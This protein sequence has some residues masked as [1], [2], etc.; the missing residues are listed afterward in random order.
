M[1]ILGARPGIAA[2]IATGL[3]AIPTSREEDKKSERPLYQWGAAIP[4]TVIR[5]APALLARRFQD[6]PS[7]LLSPKQ[8][9]LDRTSHVV[10][11]EMAKPA[12]LL[13]LASASYFIKSAPMMI[14]IERLAQTTA[15]VYLNNP[16]AKIGAGLALTTLAC[17]TE[18]GHFPNQFIAYDMGSDMQPD[19]GTL[20]LDSDGDGVPVGLDCDDQNPNKFPLIADLGLRNELQRSVS[21]Q[22]KENAEICP[23]I[24]SG[25]SLE[26]PH[27][28][29]NIEVKGEG[30]VLDGNV[31]GTSVYDQAIRIL[32][33]EGVRVSGFKIQ[34]Y[35]EPASGA[36][37]IRVLDSKDVSLINLQITATSGFYPIRLERSNSTLIDGVSTFTRSDRGIYAEACNYTVIRNTELAA[38]LPRDYPSTGY[39]LLHFIGGIGN[40]VH[41]SRLMQGEGF[42]LFVSGNSDFTANG[43][44]INGNKMSGILLFNVRASIFN[45]NLVNSNGGYGLFPQG[46]TAENQ[47]VGNNFT[48]NVL[49]PYGSREG[50]GDAPL[51]QNTFI[52][53]IPQP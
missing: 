30:V 13:L 16:A 50:M 18:E 5:K 53:N 8:L 4:L 27:G 9:Y 37:S 48:S 3:F 26:I 41:D 40:Q 36:G 22:I 7:N 15:R 46:N 45:A 35:E 23:G 10:S 51:D 1:L 28:T 33:S 19:Y 42:G 38:T 34:S 20:P 17:E 12:N 44:T 39:G 24:Y 29:K 47:F 32:S 11:Q 31:D 43:L 14:S 21:I 52:D 25:F 2:R 49:G 6:N